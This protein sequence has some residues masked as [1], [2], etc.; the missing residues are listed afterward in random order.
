MI[1]E[2]NVDDI[3]FRNASISVMNYLHKNLN[4]HQVINGVRKYYQIPVFYSKAQDSQFMKDY[5]TQ[6]KSECSPVEYVEGDFDLEP[7]VII[8]LSNIS[9]KTSDMTNKFIRGSY[10]KTEEDANGYKVNKGYSAM[11]YSLPM[12]LNFSIEIRTDDNI[13]SFRI[14]QSLL[15]EIFKNNVIHFT[16][17]GHRIRC[18]IGLD[19]SYTHDKKIQFDDKDETKDRVKTSIFVECYYPIFDKSTEIF[20]GNVIKTFRKYINSN[21][22]G[23]NSGLQHPHGVETNEIIQ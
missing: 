13:Q 12:D 9:V 7:F 2:S 15:D 10:V 20:R 21:E 5:F 8:N 23:V 22:L 11:L 17:K 18:N 4:I 19:N 16:Y 3:F 1:N 14:I 6:Y